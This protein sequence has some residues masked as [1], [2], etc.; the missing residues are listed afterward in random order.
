MVTLLALLLFA[1]LVLVLTL[2]FQSL[3]A[4]RISNDVARVV[5]VGLFFVVALAGS[6]YGLLALALS[7]VFYTPTTTH[8]IDDTYYFTQ[9]E[10]GFATMMSSGYN[11]T[12]YQKRP[13]W[14][15]Q[16]LGKMQLECLGKETIRAKVKPV[17]NGHI[18]LRIAADAQERVDTTLDTA[19]PFNFRR[20]FEDR[21]VDFSKR[22]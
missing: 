19:S 8:S 1:G 2:A 20:T 5:A 16:E 17:G 7:A 11:L 18:S 12:F 4:H 6:A 9:Q 10:Y 22:P 15:N 3:V 13:F 21:T 14:L